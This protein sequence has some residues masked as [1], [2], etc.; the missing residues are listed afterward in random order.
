MVSSNRGAVIKEIVLENF[1]S[2]EYARIPLDPGLNLISG[3]N[4]SGKSS[5]LLAISVALG[6]AYTERSK[7]LS[8]LI[9]KGRETARVSLIFDNRPIGGKRPI[10]ISKADT[11][12][13]SRYLKKDGS[14]WY[15]A[16]YREVS[17]YRIQRIFRRMGLNPDNMLIIMHQNMA[18]E[19]TVT[20][21]KKKLAM[22]EDA[23]GFG[24]YRA[25]IKEAK[26]RLSELTGEEESVSQV[27]G[28]A[29]Q[30]LSYW[31]ET[32]E[33]YLRKEKLEERLG[34]LQREL[35][36]ARVARQEK[37]LKTLEE[38]I[39][40]RMVEL[41]RIRRRVEEGERKLKE[42]DSK[43]KSSKMEYRR[44][45]FS[46]VEAEKAR[47]RRLAIQEIREKLESLPL[48][49]E[50]TEEPKRQEADIQAIHA[51]LAELEEEIDERT[52]ELINLRTEQALMD[53]RGKLLEG[54]IKDLEGWAQEARKR[55][56]ALKPER[57]EAGERI[58]TERSI[59]E[60]KEEMEV[61]R[62]RIGGL[63]EIP[64]EAERMYGDYSQLYKE[65]KERLEKVKE[66]RERAM[67]AVKRRESVWKRKLRELTDRVNP[68][69][70]EIM[71]K[72]EA[73][74]R[75]RLVNL[76][77]MENAG[78]EIWVSFRGG[79]PSQLDSRTQS[80]GE[81]SATVVAFLLALQ[82]H[83]RAPF[84]AVDE[85]DMHLDTRNREVVFK[86]IVSTVMESGVQYIVITP[87]LVTAEREA[88]LIVV[89]NTYGS[90]EV[91]E[92]D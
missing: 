65:L 62:A 36:W 20:S 24:E 9:R 68:I 57:E 12:L 82:R 92:V 64:E 39:E 21:A 7:R 4:G 70:E 11:F 52:E 50:G 19:F 87:R 37:T 74:G 14:Y 69:F 6:Q 90:S 73:G 77:D 33:K 34:Y 54:K 86:L 18:E 56:A 66:N 75:V 13:L 44:S 53:Y 40:G 89:Q 72:M 80:G 60:I 3:P 63:G 85:Y 25:K 58:A 48:N 76:R 38:R 16:D 28:S 78:L 49:V 55:L 83:V 71:S 17:K 61:V 2:Y 47:A 88:N 8:D 41:R 84:L 59:K 22:V 43:L 91:S 79:E 51:R 10:D 35:L 42:K 27:M 45:F 23:V 31:K 67:E 46:L 1:M 5:I 32:Y 29:E 26:S 30:T 81:R 15:E